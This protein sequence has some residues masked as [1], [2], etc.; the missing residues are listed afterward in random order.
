MAFFILIHHFFRCLKWRLKR[1]KC[2]FMVR[3]GAAFY[4]QVFFSFASYI[5]LRVDYKAIE[6]G[7]KMDIF[8]F[9]FCLRSSHAAYRRADEA[10]HTKHTREGERLKKLSINLR[11]LHFTSF[12]FECMS[13]ANKHMMMV[14]IVRSLFLHV[15]YIKYFSRSAAIHKVTHRHNTENKHG[16]G[17][18]VKQ[19][20]R[21]MWK[22]SS[23]IAF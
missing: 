23:C 15:N 1:T 3:L 14:I 21:D 17:V 7:Q 12:R 2:F 13:E 19:E 9:A 6:M 5:N 4:S 11:F 10:C 18:N 16:T 20:D 8:T 22:I